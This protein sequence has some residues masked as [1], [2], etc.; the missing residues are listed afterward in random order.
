MKALTSV[1]KI[2]ALLTVFIL[3]LTFISCGSNVPPENGAEEETTA[4]IPLPGGSISIPYTTGDS[5]NPFFMK[6]VLNSS[7]IS[8]VYRS[9][10]KINTSFMPENDLAASENLTGLTLKV[11]LA[12]D[13]FFSDGTALTAADVVYSFEKAKDSYLYE[14][15]LSNIVSCKEGE[16]NSIIFTLSQA[17]VNALSS[18]IFP[19]VR[20]NTAETE[21]LLPTGNGCYQFS[22]DG[23]RLTLKANLKASGEIPHVGTV[24]LTDVKG[25]TTPENLV[26]TGE[27]DFYYSDLSDS[28]IT[29]VN[30]LVTNVYLNS[31]VYLGVNHDNVNLVLASF[32]QAISCAINRPGIVENAYRGFARSTVSPF[33]ISWKKYS[34]SPSAAAISLGE[35][36][37]KASSLLSARGFGANGQEMNF[38]LLCNE[39]SSFMRNTASLIAE[40]LAEHNINI[41][42]KLLNSDSLREA[43]EAG[44]FDL[45]LAEIKVSPTMDLSQ[46]F[47]AYGEASY[48][49]NFENCISDDA[50]AD[51]VSGDGTIDE[52]IDAFS[53]EMPF[54]PILYRN[55]RLCYTRRLSSEVVAAEGNIFGN[56]PEWVFAE[57]N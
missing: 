39:G 22:Q 45:Y 29:G 44:N 55:G 27:I 28:D 31:L 32:R 54:I 52:F 8:L 2:I 37:V 48:G 40:A 4:E 16:G 18:L 50:Y 53:Q 38:T 21:D 17:D 46:F 42:V 49:I 34:S 12:D 26:S 25:N 33:N 1:K 36:N 23:I 43:V 51:Y 20:Q 7:L 9:L 13:L 10:Y 47:S 30:S 56:I 11:Y 19:V 5:L 6:T 14:N 24:R 35:D 57:S 41:T 3:I 15:T